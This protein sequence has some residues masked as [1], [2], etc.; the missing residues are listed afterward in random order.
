MFY[1]ASESGI[2]V[3]RVLH[4]RMDVARAFRDNEL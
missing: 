3:L 4:P 2:T 1:L